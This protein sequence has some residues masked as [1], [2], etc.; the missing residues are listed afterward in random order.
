MIIAWKD[1]SMRINPVG[2]SIYSAVRQFL[3]TLPGRGTHVAKWSSPPLVLAEDHY[4]E[5]AKCA[6][7]TTYDFRWP[8]VRKWWKERRS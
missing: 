8:L 3:S 5:P 2:R 6:D 1:R 7:R 4:I